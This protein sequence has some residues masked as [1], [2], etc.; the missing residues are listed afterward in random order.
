MRHDDDKHTDVL[1]DEAAALYRI[2]AADEREKAR[3]TMEKYVERLEKH[4]YFA[5]KRDTTP[6]HRAGPNSGRKFGLEYFLRV[7]FGYENI[8]DVRGELISLELREAISP[9]LMV[10]IKK[11]ERKMRRLQGYDLTR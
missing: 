8:G 9:E 7:I 1:L 10:R 4:C 6:G 3:K 11:L 2:V 5:A